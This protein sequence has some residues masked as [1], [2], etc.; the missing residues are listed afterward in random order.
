MKILTRL[1]YTLVVNGG[2]FAAVLFTSFWIDDNVGIW[3]VSM[4]FNLI[5]AGALISLIV[6]VIASFSND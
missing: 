3:I 2:I 4:A 5:V 6:G 1:L